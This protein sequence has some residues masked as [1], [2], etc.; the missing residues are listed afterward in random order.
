MQDRS[1]VIFHYHLQPGGVSTVISL[2]VRAIA[3]SLPAIDR[4]ELVTGRRD[5]TGSFLAKLKKAVGPSGPEIVLNVHP[6]LDYATESHMDD[7][8]RIADE[9]FDKYSGPIWWVH[10]YQLGKNPS[11]TEALLR[12]ASTHT[13]QRLIFHIHDFPECARYQNL[14]LLKKHTSLPVYPAASNVRYAVI[15]GRDHD[16]LIRAGIP[17]GHVFL[18]TNPVDAAPL[19]RSGA[20][21]T[22][23]E[24]TRAFSRDFPRYDP[25]A[26]MVLSPVRTIRRKNIL[27]C[28]LITES[29]DRP[30]NL[31]VTLPGVSDREKPYSDVV[32]GAFNRGLVTGLWGVGERLDDEGIGFERFVA[33]ADLILSASVQEGFGLFYIEALLWGMPLCARRIDIL[34]GVADFLDRESVHLYH[35]LEVPLTGEERSGLLSRYDERIERLSDFIDRGIAE[36]LRGD[37]FRLTSAEL[38]DYSYLDVGLQLRVLERAVDSAEY[39]TEIRSSNPELYRR[40]E[41]LIEASGSVEPAP[42]D[43][44]FTFAGFGRVTRAIFDSFEKNGGIPG[45]SGNESGRTAVSRPDASSSGTGAADAGAPHV[46]SSAADVQAN[47]IRAFARLEYFRLLYE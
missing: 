35:G 27:E 10:N 20:G 2:S 13:G 46:E 39:R 43:E 44:R 11:F 26:P 4:V 30:A 36:S 31:V 37:A 17:S 16:L 18:L 40:L 5:D 9:L 47:L 34:G 8:D 41:G 1:I 14:E 23:S 12:I 42:V 22:R 38:V 45:R 29:A 21:E 7:P 6:S 15:N 19:D 3:E 28:A 33:S 25:D 32:E 24:I